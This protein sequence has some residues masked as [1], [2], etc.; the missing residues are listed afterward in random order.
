MLQYFMNKPVG[1]AAW[2]LVFRKFA[3][4]DPRLSESLG[5][6]AGVV[7]ALHDVLEVAFSFF[8]FVNG[9]R[10]K[11]K[12]PPH[13]LEIVHRRLLVLANNQESFRQVSLAATPLQ[14]IDQRPGVL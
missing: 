3:P 5:S 11:A 13:G 4:I 9:S 12:V 2:V 14:F 6:L 10:G 1:L 8:I 7:Y